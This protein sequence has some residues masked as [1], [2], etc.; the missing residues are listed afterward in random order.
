MRKKLIVKFMLPTIAIV[1]VMMLALGGITVRLL[2]S[3]VRGRANGE[4]TAEAERVLENLATVDALSSGEVRSAMKML[5]R[6]GERQGAPEIRNTATLG[7]EVLPNLH[8]GG[9]PQIGNFTLVDRIKDITENTATI[10]VRH[11]NSFVRVSTNVLRADGSRAVGT[12]LDPQGPAYAAIQEQKPYYGIADILGTPYMTAYEPMRN[13]SG[14]VIGVWYVGT[15]LATVA[16]LGKHISSAKILNNGYVALLSPS[17]KVIFKSSHVREEDVQHRR[18]AG[19][20]GGWTVI[21]QPYE[22]WGYTLLAAYPEEDIA[23][24]LHQ[25]QLVITS[26]ALAL[27]VLVVSALY[28][29]LSRLVL[30]PVFNLVQVAENIASGDLR[31]EVK[32]TAEDETGKLQAAMRRMS[33]SLSQMIAEVRMGASA[34]S[35]AA[36]QVSASAQSVS[37]GTSEQAASVEETTSSLEQMNASINQNSDNS[38]Q[39]EQAAAKGAREAEESGKVVKQTVEAMKS[40]TEKIEIIDEIAYQTNLLAL[41]AAIEA[42]RAGE[43]GKGFAVVATEVRKLAERSQ[44]AAKEIGN[45]ASD[46]VKVAEQSGRLLDELVPSIKKTAEMVQEVAAASVEQSSGVNQINK[47]MSQ[48]DQVT[49]RNASAAEELSSTAEELASQSEAL[50]QL[51]NFFK[52]EDADAALSVA[53]HGRKTWM[54]P[55]Q[56]AFASD[57]MRAHQPANSGDE[58]WRPYSAEQEKT[59]GESTQARGAGA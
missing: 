58:D 13:K 48:V 51:M 43:H 53:K 11:G 5:I 24:K 8:V 47:A 10:F 36:A 59:E 30:K 38:R 45:L 15:P 22:K 21:S 33:G 34:L 46:S 14:Q 41:N 25:V 57:R 16:E 4:A 54:P 31:D 20:G 32:V 12:V 18:Q 49:Q 35:S 19:T 6:E 52:I 9:V 2:E 28:L 42:A 50:L 55:V 40:I 39:M 17:G 23:G 27:A 7:G 44:E 3:E 37:Q 29:L 56:N 1:I 26:C